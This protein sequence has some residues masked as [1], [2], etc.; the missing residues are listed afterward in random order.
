MGEKVINCR[1]SQEYIFGYLGKLP[2]KATFFPATKVK[3]C[4]LYFHGGG[5]VFGHR[6]D[7]PTVYRQL[8]VEAGY[9]VITLDYPLAPEADLTTIYLAAKRGV[10]WFIEE[11][12]RYSGHTN[13][14]YILF[15]RSAGGYLATLLTTAAP[16]A[17]QKGLIRFYGYQQLLDP[18]FLAP[19]AYY[20]HYPKVTPSSAQHLKRTSP[21]TSG[22]LSERFPLYLSARQFGNWH[23]YLGKR[24]TL[25]ELDKQIQDF[26]NLM[27]TF[28]AHC[29]NDPDVPVQQSKDFANQLIQTE[30]YWLS[31]AEH[32]FD[33]Q[34][35]PFADRCYRQLIGWLDQV[36]KR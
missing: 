11:G 25:L 35:T 9:T 17:S 31:Q 8:L 29:E 6:N 36:G 28:L 15:G 5:F 33:R 13:S 23:T 10:D 3:G 20:L 24:Q 26:P 27:P 19:S 34:E 32:D 1:S 14:D 12:W 4:I 2:L 18:R 7:L 21:V 16:Y 22:E 30:T